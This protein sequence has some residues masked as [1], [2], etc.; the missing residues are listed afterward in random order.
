MAKT[1]SHRERMEN[2]LSGKVQSKIPTA[3]WRHFP[4]DDQKADTFAKAVINFQSTFEFDFIKVTPASSY[5]VKPWGVEDVW[6]GNPH[7]TRDY[8]KYVIE[9]PEDWEKLSP[10]NPDEGTLGMVNQCLEMLV[11]HYNTHTPI[12]Q[13]IFSPLSQAKNI[14]GPEKLLL[15]LRNFPKAV[16]A[17]LKTITENTLQYLNFIAEIG[18]DGI[19]YAV[20][21]AQHSL[22]TEN[23]FKTFGKH[24]DMQILSSLDR[25]WLNVGHIHGE[26][27]MF[28][29]V[30]DYPV[31]ILNWH[32]QDTFP[33]LSQAKK[34][35]DAAVCGGIK[36]EETM[37]LGTP[38]EIIAEAENAV[39]ET[40]G[41]RFI[42]GTGCV[43]PITA[44]YGN[45]ISASNHQINS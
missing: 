26:D 23:E 12:I 42:L 4:V 13:T 15:H 2:C 44:P 36:Q 19:F 9:K 5:C 27:I 24:Y 6:T 38:D 45:I 21:H 8:T 11:N 37:V 41:E 14:V 43:L 29:Q 30:A 33:S 3:L 31:Q 22:L 17:G 7:G 1:I 10:V 25:F 39:S 18:I 40:N 28:K 32:D 35:T 20:Q 34:L 16:H